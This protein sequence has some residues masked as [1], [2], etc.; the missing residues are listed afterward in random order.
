MFQQTP[1]VAK[2][3]SEEW[4]NMKPEDRAV[5]DEKARLDKERFEVEKALYTGP[6]KIPVKQKSVK[7]PGAPK[8]PMSSFLSYSNSKRSEIKRTHPGISNSDASKLLARMWKE[9]PYEEKREH[10]E[11]EERLREIYKREISEYRNKKKNDIEEVR[12]ERE[13]AALRYIDNRAKG[14]IDESEL[15]SVSWG[16][17]D[18]S[19]NGT[20]PEQQ[21]HYP[22]HGAYDGGASYDPYYSHPYHQGYHAPPPPHGY[23]GGPPPPPHYYAAHGQTPPPP[24]YAH[25]AHQGE[26]RDAP[27]PPHGHY[28]YYDDG[29]G[30]AP[31][32]Y[33]PLHHP[34]AP[35]PGQ[36]PGT[37]SVAGDAAKNVQPGQNEGA[38]PP[39][40]HG[41]AG[42]YYYGSNEH[43]PPPAPPL[44]GHHYDGSYSEHYASQQ[45]PTKDAPPVY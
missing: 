44:D 13:K 4:R 1:D 40:D 30:Y 20:N 34:P 18:G 22:P 16:P 29:Y 21:G 19:N 14:I 10:I 15:L 32:H 7:D 8:R 24:H 25:G 37:E 6:W 23:H 45:P 33:H 27:P 38:P 5:W 31:Q 3:I 11:R 41:A 17:N 42:G 35:A 26:G 12:E 39:L 9:A 36:A 28:G 43:P 2:I